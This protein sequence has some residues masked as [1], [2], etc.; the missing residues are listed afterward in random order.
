MQ[1]YA[2]DTGDTSKVLETLNFNAQTAEI[3]DKLEEIRAAVEE[4]NNNA[5]ELTD[6]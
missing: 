3:V 5:D 2:E 4:G 6:N 1:K